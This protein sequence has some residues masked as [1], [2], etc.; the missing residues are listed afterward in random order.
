MFL[1]QNR[2]IFLKRSE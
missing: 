2:A 1:R